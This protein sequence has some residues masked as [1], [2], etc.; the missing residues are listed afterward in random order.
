MAAAEEVA[1][2]LQGRLLLRW[3]CAWRRPPLRLLT[4]RRRRSRCA[5]RWPP[6]RPRRAAKPARAHRIRM[7]S[8]CRRRGCPPSACAPHLRAGPARLHPRPLLRWRPPLLLPLRRHRQ[9]LGLSRSG[10]RRRRLPPC[11]A[12]G[13]ARWPPQQ[14]PCWP[15]RRLGRLR[16]LRVHR[17]AAGGR[18][19][20]R[21]ASRARRTPSARR[22]R[23]RTRRG[24]WRS[25]SRARRDGNGRLLL[26][27]AVTGGTSCMSRLL[28]RSHSLRAGSTP[29]PCGAKRPPGP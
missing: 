10:A 17:R 4:W 13:A 29:R 25:C 11:A 26:S 2:A 3:T 6:R 1:I 23:R 22:R 21:R 19:P 24:S 28:P 8:R 14:P 15:Q 7:C 12:G 18:M 27:T 9:C 20:L 16:R 5:P